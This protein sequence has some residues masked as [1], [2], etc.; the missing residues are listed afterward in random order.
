MEVTP[1]DLSVLVVTYNSRAFVDDCIESVVRTVTRHR[2]EILVADNASDDGTADHVR[3]SH[4]GV[5][6]IDMGA[7]TGFAAANNRACAASSGRHVVLL[8]GDAVASDGALDALV[9]FLDA[10]P[11]AGVVAPRLLNPD[12]TDQGTARAFPTPAAAVW[13]RRSPLTRLLPRNR[14]SRRYL[15]GREHRGDEPFEVD[16]VS[17]ACLMVPRRIVDE[18]GDLDTGFFMYWEDADWCRRIK[19]AGYRVWCV[20]AARVVHAE[21]GSRRGWPARQV[22]HFHRSAYRYYA[23]HH[24]RG[25]RRPLRPLAGVTMAVRAGVVILRDST[26]RIGPGR[27]TDVPIAPMTRGGAMKAGELQ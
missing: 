12:G 27:Q 8:N 6:V 7:N 1:L 3:A 4:P 17:G 9:D 22:R 13:G 19:D 20:P 14:F 5:R 2:C 15:V 25:L 26:R 10:H 11:T 16:W 21:G 18:V 23:K 24:L